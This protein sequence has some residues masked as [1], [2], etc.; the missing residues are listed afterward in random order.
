MATGCSQC[1]NPK[2]RS[3]GLCN[4]HYLRHSRANKKRGSTYTPPTG[5]TTTLPPCE[6]SPDCLACPLPICKYDK[7]GQAAL[8]D[9]QRSKQG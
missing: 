8:R 5:L 7:G 2:I 1:G 3:L 9:W 4:A 6:V